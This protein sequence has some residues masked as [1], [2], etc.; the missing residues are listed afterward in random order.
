MTRVTVVGAGVSGLTT[1]IVLAERGHFVEVLSDRPIDGT[2]SAAAGAIWGP[3]LVEPKDKVLQWGAET[4][5]VLVDLSA[6]PVETGVR[7]TTGVVAARDGVVDLPNWANLISD[8]RRCGPSELPDGFTDG[9]RYAVPV[10]DMALYLPYLLNRLADDGGTVQQRHLNTLSAITNADV[11]VNCSGLGA[12]ALIGDTSL[13]PIRGQ[14]VV[15]ENPGLDEFFE[16]ETGPSPDL[17]CIY[18]Q[19]ERA[20][21]GGTAVDGAWDVA[22]DPRVAEAIISRCAA[23]R[24][25]LSQ[26]E[27]LGVRVGLRPTRDAI[28]VEQG[29]P[30]R[31]DVPVF[32]NYG[33]GGAGVSL[34]W[35]CAREVLRLL[36][37]EETAEGFPG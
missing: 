4:L 8:V 14:L 21:L 9:V 1:A 23:I 11:I 25:Q 30:V 22:P 15:V 36:A 3:Y 10:I 27:V 17:L 13:R 31:D 20:I 26:A 24:P 19:G 2:T 16:E 7:M 5:Q 33:H 28:R 35:G 37:R 34:S 32:H 6:R 29:P 18:P 12:H